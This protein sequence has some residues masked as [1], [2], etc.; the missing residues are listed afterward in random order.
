MHR[1]TLAASGLSKKEYSLLSKLNTP[2]K[3]QDYLDALPFNFEKKGDTHRSPRR[4]LADS[5]CHCIEGA[6]LAAVA[7]WIQG[8]QPL[9]MNLSA[10][11]GRGDVDHVIALYKRG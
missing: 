7:L 8:E 4:V 3:I 2:I 11:M 9:I 10:R 5:K 6:M 1:L